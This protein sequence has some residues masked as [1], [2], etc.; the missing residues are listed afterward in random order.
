MEDQITTI[1][2]II[3]T[4]VGVIVIAAG[5]AWRLYKAFKEKFGKWLE[6]TE[7][8]ADKAELAANTNNGL[9][10]QLQAQ[11][12]SQNQAISALERALN[13]N[14]EERQA[15]REALLE[16]RKRY[17]AKIKTLEDKIAT[18]ETQQQATIGLQTEIISGLEQVIQ[19]WGEL[20][21][22]IVTGAAHDDKVV[23]LDE[24][25][26]SLKKI[27]TRKRTTGSLKGRATDA[28]ETKKG[29]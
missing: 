29:E 20:K 9:L 12:I 28:D 19:E 22:A 3:G 14:Q 27:A 7:K 23:D 10:K 6:K 1:G 15:A 24:A 4:A 16:E 26:D 17:D 18:F 5:V 2:T 8:K 11:I 13:E 21:I 25:L